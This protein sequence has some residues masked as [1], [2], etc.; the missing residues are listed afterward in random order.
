MLGDIIVIA[1]LIAIIYYAIK[2]LKKG[3]SCSGNCSS[4][5]SGSSSCHVD[6]EEVRKKVKED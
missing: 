6:W 1:I 5:M 2:S 3:D 4:C